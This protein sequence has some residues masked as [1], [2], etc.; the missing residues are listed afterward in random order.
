MGALRWGGAAL[1][2]AAALLAGTPP[3]ATAQTDTTAVSKVIKNLKPTYTTGYGVERQTTNW[4]QDF[5]MGAGF[6][7]L[8]FNNRTQFNVHT[9]SNRDEE[10]RDGSN[11]LDLTFKTLPFSSSINLNR[12]SVT[13]PSDQRQADQLSFS[14]N[15]KGFGRSFFTIRNDVNFGGGYD[16]RSDLSVSRDSRSE[17]VNRGWNGNAGWKVN[18]APSNQFTVVSNLQL[19]R[20][21]KTSILKKEGE[22]EQTKPTANRGR[23]VTVVVHVEPTSWVGADVNALDNSSNDQYYIVTSGTGALE[24]KASTRRSLTSRFTLLKN[25]SGLDLSLD[26]GANDHDLSY[27]VNRDIASSGNGTSWRWNLGTTI[28]GT[29]VT[30]DLSS[31]R[32][33]LTPATSAGTDSRNNQFEGEALWPSTQGRN[34][35]PPPRIALKFNWL[36][37]SS[38]LFFSNVEPAFMY[39]KD[40]LRTKLQPTLTYNPNNRWTVVTS[41]TRS[42]TRHVELN[43]NRANQTKRDED[44]TVDMSISC[45]LSARTTLTQVYSIKALYST[46]D[47][48]ARQD[49]L[50]ATQRITTGI[51]SQLTKDVSIDVQHHFTLQ[52]SGPFEYDDAGARVFARDLRKY[53]QELEGDV[54]YT[55]VPWCTFITK[56]HF[57]RTDDVNEGAKTRGM[58]RTLDLSQGV[59]MSQNLQKGMTIK[60][61]AYYVQSSTQNPYWSITSNLTKNF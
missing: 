36:V 19:T 48:S 56:S 46:F 37:R 54:T 27:D 13:R 22:D 49:R 31:Q 55:V 12:T 16:S 7:F 39:D 8:D 14:L 20:S 32:D 59:E 50:L 24:K 38:Q 21:D 34:V 30:S 29:K 1:A 41:F 15:S 18:Y 40:E 2:A 45:K 52:D 42:V 43:P 35:N 28:W 9:D 58:T 3:P 25:V 10:R 57:L 47:Y 60:G 4:T 5:G 53:R 23:N 17:S 33:V 44:Y 6:S 61:T 51:Q 11:K 26:L